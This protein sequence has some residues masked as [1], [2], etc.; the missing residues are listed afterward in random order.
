[1]TARLSSIQGN[2]CGHRPHLQL[3]PA[4]TR[5]YVQSWRSFNRSATVPA[6][7]PLRN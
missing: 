6:K 4:K 5:L 1:M 2:T 7:E 3:E